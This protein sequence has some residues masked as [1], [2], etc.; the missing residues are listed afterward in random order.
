MNPVCKF[1]EHWEHITSEIQNCGMCSSI[2]SYLGSYEKLNVKCI[3]DEDYKDFNK[4][5]HNY[6]Q[7]VDNTTILKN[8]NLEVNKQSQ[9]IRKLYEE[10]N[11]LQRRLIKILS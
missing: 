3:Y 11:E 9:L 4:S 1:C 5:K 6:F 10:I 8:Y 2:T 7:P